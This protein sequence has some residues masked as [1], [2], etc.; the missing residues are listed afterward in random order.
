MLQSSDGVELRGAGALYK[1][2]L[3][4]ILAYIVL[5]AAFGQVGTILAAPMAVLIIGSVTVWLQSRGQ[6]RHAMSLFVWGIW[7]AVTMQ[8]VLRNG[9][10]NAALFAYPAMMLL[11]GWAAGCSAH[12]RVWHLGWHRSVHRFSLPWR[13]ITG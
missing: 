9:V 10:A 1:A 6:A 2:V 7:A 3:G 13:S 11:G 8:G 5:M 12:A 4:I